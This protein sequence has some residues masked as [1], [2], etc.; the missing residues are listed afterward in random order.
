MPSIVKCVE[1]GV[2]FEVKPYMAETRK[3]CSTACKNKNGRLTLT[4][5]HCNQPFWVFKSAVEYQSKR[6]CSMA[7]RKTVM[8]A[9][10]KPPKVAKEKVFKICKT[11]G[12]EF[13]VPLC[14]KETA[15]YCSQKCKGSDP[16][17]KLM[18]SV[19]QRGEKSAKFVDGQFLGKDGYMREKAWGHESAVETFAHRVIVAYALAAES[20]SHPFLTTIDGLTRLRPEIHVHHIDRNKL[21]ND[22]SNL[23]AV[24]ASAHIRLHKSG[25]KPDPWECWPSNPT[26]W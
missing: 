25:R 18:S 8:A 13:R 15:Q 3:F 17:Y 7:C 26:N 14:R 16:A 2:N 9:K 21:N 6:F 23:L 1:C 12:I 5:E 22:L 4:C 10:P 19:A 24:T 20:P 11:C